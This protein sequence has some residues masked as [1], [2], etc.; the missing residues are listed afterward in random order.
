[1]APIRQRGGGK[2]RPD[3]S[4]TPTR[5]NIAPSKSRPSGAST[6]YPPER[7]QASL[8]T[9]RTPSTPR[10]AQNK[11]TLPNVA[12]GSSGRSSTRSGRA[13]LPEDTGISPGRRRRRS[14][15]VT[16]ASDSST[17]SRKASGISA[18]TSQTTPQTPVSNPPGQ[19]VSDLAVPDRPR[20]LSPLSYTTFFPEARQ[21]NETQNKRQTNNAAPPNIALEEQSLPT[22]DIDEF[23]R[24]PHWERNA[25][26]PDPWEAPESTDE[27]VRE[28]LGYRSPSPR[29][30]IVMRPGLSSVAEPG[31]FFA[32]LYQRTMQDR[33]P[34]EIH[35][36]SSFPSPAMIT[37]PLPLCTLP[38]RSSLTFPLPDAN[39]ANMTN[40]QPVVEANHKMRRRMTPDYQ[41]KPQLS[42]C[43]HPACPAANSRH[44]QGQ[45]I[46]NGI[47]A[48]NPLSTFGNSNPPASVWQSIYNGCQGNGTQQDADLISR[49]I[50][51]HVVGSAFSVIPDTN[52]IWGEEVHVWG[53]DT[54][55]GRPLVSLPMMATPLRIKFDALPNILV[56]ERE[57]S[58][59]ALEFHQ[60]DGAADTA[61]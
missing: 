33:E 53:D 60:F 58:P 13:Y 56:S 38:P 31:G 4:S 39:A 55:V 43:M 1:M 48:L 26:L 7:S 36:A 57:D 16:R 40:S 32:D 28:N 44:S 12:I 14:S 35:Y 47:P 54:L 18:A 25:D 10:P 30:E 27:W 42:S 37:A 5:T 6:P 20:S 15:A 46:H 29:H 22:L 52:F 59:D 50:H 49:F 11:S 45:Y 3:I 41:V 19:I 9:P 21:H 51:H 34:P 24:M 17:P 23:I 61:P 2:T 8:T